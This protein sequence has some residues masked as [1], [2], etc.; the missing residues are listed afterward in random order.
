MASKERMQTVIKQCF[1]NQKYKYEIDTKNDRWTLVSGF[2]GVE[3]ESVTTGLVISV[4]NDD[5]IFLGVSSNKIPEDKLADTAEFFMR[6]NQ[7][8]KNG[9]FIVDYNNQEYSF[10]LWCTTKGRLSEKDVL[11]FLNVTVGSVELIT[12]W[13]QKVANGE[14]IPS[15]ASD[16]YLDDVTGVTDSEKD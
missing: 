16:Q 6:V 8:I 10:K 13:V 2:Q 3:D 15:E 12:S 5:I 9:H 11:H 1:D 4:T 7:C 14:L